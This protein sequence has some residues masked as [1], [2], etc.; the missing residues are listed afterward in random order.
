ML[1]KTKIKPRTERGLIGTFIFARKLDEQELKI[2]IG[3]FPDSHLHT[4]QGEHAGGGQQFVL[5]EP[6]ISREDC[7]LPR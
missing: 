5:I 1:N 7:P 2:Q 4:G 3:P 6:I